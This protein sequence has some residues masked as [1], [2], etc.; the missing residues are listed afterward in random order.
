V[1][2]IVEDMKNEFLYF[3]QLEK[4]IEIFKKV[5]NDS[6]TFE[7]YFYWTEYAKDIELVFIEITQYLEKYLKIVK[8]GRLSDSKTLLNG[9]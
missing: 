6:L 4:S 5:I 2:D 7:I 9:R 8:R 3:Q 1:R